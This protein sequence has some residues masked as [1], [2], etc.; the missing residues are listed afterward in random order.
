[1]FGNSHWIIT[2]PLVLMALIVMTFIVEYLAW[3][4]CKFILLCVYMEKQQ[5]SGR[6]G[7]FLVQLADEL[8]TKK[9]VLRIDLLQTFIF[10]V[11]VMIPVCFGAFCYSLTRWV[12][13]RLAFPFKAMNT[14]LP[15]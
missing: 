1:M 14:P 11:L 9:N 6:F 4:A 7:L 10:F 15:P 13:E 12:V 3:L 2:I 8:A 5:P